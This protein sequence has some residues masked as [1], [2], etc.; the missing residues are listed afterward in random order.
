VVRFGDRT[1]VPQLCGVA[2][3]RGDE[4]HPSID[5]HAFIAGQL[6]RAGVFGLEQGRRYEAFGTAPGTSH[7]WPA[8]QGVSVLPVPRP[9]ATTRDDQRRETR[10]PAPRWRR[11]SLRRTTNAGPTAPPAGAR[12]CR[13]SRPVPAATCAPVDADRVDDPTTWDR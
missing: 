8:V 6:A 7:G 1:A 4:P 13:A 10:H 2:G 11:T 3:D 12:S 9:A 5:I